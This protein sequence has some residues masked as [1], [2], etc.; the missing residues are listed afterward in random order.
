MNASGP[1]G[2]P[3]IN[4]NINNI[5]HPNNNIIEY[6]TIVEINVPIPFKRLTA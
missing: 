3:L 2:A 4:Q 5:V 1:I 6:G